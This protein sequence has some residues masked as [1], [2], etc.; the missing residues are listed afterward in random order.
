MSTKQS[1]SDILGAISRFIK[2]LFLSTFVHETGHLLVAWLLGVDVGIPSI[3]YFVGF[4]PV[5]SDL[6]KLPPLVVTLIAYAGPLLALLFGIWVWEKD[7]EW[8][9][10]TFLYSVLPSLLPIMPGSDAYQAVVYGRFP[11]FLAWL[12]FFS[13]LSL[14]AL[15]LD[16]IRRERTRP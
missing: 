14:I 2:Y 1:V 4:T 13:A 15:Y 9:I 6:S 11:L 8:A 12:I 16:E 7:K 5:Y 3:T 10:V